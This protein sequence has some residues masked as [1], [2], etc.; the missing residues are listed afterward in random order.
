MLRDV[1]HAQTVRGRSVGDVYRV[2]HSI[3]VLTSH[4][5]NVS[6][7]INYM[8]NIIKNIWKHIEP[9]T[10]AALPMRRFSEDNDDVYTWE[11][12]HRDTRRDYPFRYWL[13]HT[14]PQFFWPMQRIVKGTW[15]WLKCHTLP[16]YRYHMLDLR[17]PGPGIDYTYGWL[18]RDTVILYAAFTC[19]RQ[20][21]EKEEPEDPTKW[22]TDDGCDWSEHKKHHDEVMA[23]YDWWMRERLEDIAAEEKAW[24]ACYNDHKDEEARQVWLDTQQL[25]ED[26][27]QEML[28]RLVNVRRYMWT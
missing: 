9:P 5:A 4:K 6:V 24:D 7:P 18:D 28:I 15:Y 27:E 12:W 17:N 19:L 10:P 20:F 26:R 16:S 13:T 8:K 14:F 25:N 22:S 3:R 23:L 1:F 21:V 11:D 2:K